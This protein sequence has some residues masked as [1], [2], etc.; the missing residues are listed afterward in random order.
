MHQLP[1][2][3]VLAMTSGDLYDMPGWLCGCLK[4]SVPLSWVHGKSSTMNSN[5]EE[6]GF[7]DGVS[8]LDLPPISAAVVA[9]QAS[10]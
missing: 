2:W 9:Q 10:Q 7:A 6:E 4:C 1:R 8:L 5:H 3:N